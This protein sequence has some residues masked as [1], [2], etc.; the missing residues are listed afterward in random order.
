MML[1]QCSIVAQSLFCLPLL[2]LLY[3]LANRRKAERGLTNV[4]FLNPQD[5]PESRLPCEPTYHLVLVQE[6]VHDM[7][8]P[9]EM[10]K[11]RLLIYLTSDQNT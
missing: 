5:G 7:I 2:L 9:Q 1:R 4:M 10:L 11:V 3:S 8:N 6:A